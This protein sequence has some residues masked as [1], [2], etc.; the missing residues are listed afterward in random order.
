MN[1]IEKKQSD[2][3]LVF[4]SKENNLELPKEILE[5][6]EKANV[7]LDKCGAMETINTLGTFDY[8]RV[9]V[10]NVGKSLNAKSLTKHI[11]GAIISLRDKIAS[12]DVLNNLPEQHHLALAKIVEVSKYHYAGITK[13]KREKKLGQVNIIGGDEKHTADGTLLGEAVNTA[14]T[15]ISLPSN[16]INPVSYLNEIEIFANDNGLSFEKIVGQR[17]DR[18][19]FG[20][21]YAVG[22]GS[23]YP[24]ALAIV[25]YNGNP[26]S[27]QVTALVGKGVTFDSGGISIKGTMNMKDMIGDMG[28]SAA[29]FGTFKYLVTSKQPVNVML[30]IPLA[31]NMPSSRSYKPGDVITMYNKSTVDIVSTDAEGRMLLGDAIAYAAEQD[32]DNIIELSTLTGANA[33]YFGHFT[34]PFLCYDEDMSNA[35][36]EASLEEGENVWPMPTQKEFKAVLKTRYADMINSA[37]AGGIAAG[38][39]LDSFADN[40]PFLHIDIAGSSSMSKATPGV[41]AGPS[42]VMVATVSNLIVKLQNKQ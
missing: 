26:K 30:L 12:L 37:P 17:L 9:Y 14:R 21:I 13:K 34:T 25:K 35:F 40:T 18:L 11:G 36:V 7:E 1:F 32:V 29:A 42:G 39:F 23:D 28:G 31:E 24:P 27:D 22:K 41:E 5:L 6:I 15:L 33:R 20:G 16:V 3:L 10:V 8:Q 38:I 2:N 4:T 19:G